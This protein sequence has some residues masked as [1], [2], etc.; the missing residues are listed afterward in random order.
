MVEKL[1]VL[2]ADD[3][4]TFRQLLVQSINAEADMRVVG[5]A[6]DGQQAV[7]LARELRPDVILMDIIMPKVDGLEATREI[8]RATPTPIVVVS[9]SLESWETDT[10]FRA[11]GLGALT[12]Q[13]KPVGPRDPEHT[14]QITALLNTLRT[15]AGVRVIHHWQRG[16]KLPVVETP[17]SLKTETWPATKTS[18][19]PEIVAIASS[20]GG[21]TALSTII[22]ALPSDFAV[23]IVI[24]QH[25][26][27]GFVPALAGWLTGLTPLQIAVA[28]DRERPRPGW[29]YLAP[30]D[31]QLRLT[32]GRRFELDSRPGLSRYVPSGDILLE[33]VASSYGPRAVGVVLTGMGD[34]G[35][36]GLRAMRDA[37]AFTI[38]QD[39]ETSVVFG[40]PREAI[41]LG[42][43]QRV[44]PPSAISRMLV[45]LV[46]AG[47]AIR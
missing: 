17:A 18:Q 9:A 26:T 7:N 36:R 40:M 37:D 46:N 27:P 42:S 11:I 41:A 33:S 13:R 25:I 32:R 34:D 2:V 23:P 15:M 45:H 24:A 8:M 20:T 29:I 38:A 3:S 14:T 19:S 1:N 12:A 10:A 5:E 4:P 39:E 35:A 21:P 44:L 30:G 28:Q 16:K 43:A 47:E 22:G 6:V 31:A